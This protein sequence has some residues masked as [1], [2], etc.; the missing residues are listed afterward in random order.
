M[1]IIQASLIV[2]TLLC[3]LVAGFVFAFSV[4]VMP[5]IGELNSKEFIQAFQKIDGIIQKGQPVFAVV[6]IGSA[7]TLVVAVA[8]GMGS[9]DATGRWLLI[10]ST[11]VYFLGVQLPT[12]AINIPLNNRLQS[13]DV[14]AMDEH[15]QQA[16]RAA[17]EQRWNRWNV[18]RT[19]VSCVVTLLLLVLLLRH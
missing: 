6:W 17:F 1:G 5:G 14:D 10:V 16:A 4:V 9:L 15:A 2:S 19:V 3:S 18:I 11:L 8:L 12:F 13:L 7:L